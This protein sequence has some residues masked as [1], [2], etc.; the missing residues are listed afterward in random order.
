MSELAVAER[1]RKQVWAA[2]GGFHDRLMTALK[3]ALPALIGVLLGYLAVAP[4]TRSQ[5]I[6]F[7]LDKTKVD[8][9]SERMRVQAAQYQGQDDRGRPFTISARSAVQVTSRDP[10][11]Q[12]GGA[13]ADIILEDG[14]ASLNAD[15]GQYNLETEQVSVIGP[16]LVTAPDNYRLVT[17][18][19]TVDLNS[20]TLFSRGNVQGTMPLGTFTANRLRADLNQRSVMLDGRARLHIVQGGLR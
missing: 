3:M 5:E 15:K 4:L 8:V 13:R 2:P 7:I 1:H 20:R 6:S 14:P 9:A 12:I 10:I 11:V 19:V 17:N 18:D 16:T